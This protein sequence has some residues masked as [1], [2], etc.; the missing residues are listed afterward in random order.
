MIRWL[1]RN[2]PLG[3]DVKAVRLCVLNYSF[4]FRDPSPVSARGDHPKF[5]GPVKRPCFLAQY[6]CIFA[7]H[8]VAYQFLV[9]VHFEVTE[10]T[11]EK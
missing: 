6:H 1:D 10:V 3:F 11:N 2:V 4:V 5:T 7:V 8:E 9:V